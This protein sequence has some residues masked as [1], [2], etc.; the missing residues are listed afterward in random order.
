MF[1]IVVEGDLK[2][3]LSVATTLTSRGS[4]WLRSKLN[5]IIFEELDAVNGISALD[6]Y[7]ML[8]PYEYVFFFRE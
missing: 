4:L 7:S 2:S 1:V 3:S 8:H 6:G 5:E